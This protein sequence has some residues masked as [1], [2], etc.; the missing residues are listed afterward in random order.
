MRNL[1]IYLFSL[2]SSS[3]LSKFENLF[4]ISQGKGF[5]NPK[6]ES[7]LIIKFAN[8]NNLDLKTIFDIGC[9]KG[10]YTFE[11]LKKF[12]KSK[13]YLFEPDKTSFN[14]VKERYSDFK[15]IN[16]FNIAI[17]D[18]EE[19]GILYSYGKGSLQGSLIDQDFSHLNIKN[20][21][22][23]IVKIR[24][25]QTLFKEFE[26]D[27]IDLCKIDI[28]GNEMKSLLGMG[29]IIKKIK[30]IQFEFG[31]AS[32]DSKIF[33]KDFYNFFLNSGFK[34]YRITPSKLEKIYD[35]NESIENFR[36]TNFVAVNNEYID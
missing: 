36:V 17:S 19:E 4:S 18:K 29:Q 11:L 32:V 25:I 34:I 35:Y 21:L 27:T 15:N 6:I 24:N 20:D 31:P 5:S 23:H 33:F 13:Y 28:E 2:L 16:L 26:L 10:D 1:T 22:K 3:F 30:I 14:F 8:D 9:F 12:S 7:N